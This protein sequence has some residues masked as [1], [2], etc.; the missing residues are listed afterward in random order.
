MKRFVALLREPIPPGTCP[1]CDGIL[2]DSGCRLGNRVVLDDEVR[3]ET[4]WTVAVETFC[5]CDPVHPVRGCP[6]CARAAR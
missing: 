2:D 6:A 5:E 1:A 4:G 3:R